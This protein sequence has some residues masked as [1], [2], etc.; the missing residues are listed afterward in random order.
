LRKDKLHA[1]KCLEY[2]VSHFLPLGIFKVIAG[3]TTC[4]P[5]DFRM[6]CLTGLHP[7]THGICQR[8]DV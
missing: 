7:S 8:P 6:G 2:T 3:M 5:L 4:Q 1:A